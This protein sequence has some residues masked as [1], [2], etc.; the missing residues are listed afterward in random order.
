M[1]NIFYQKPCCK[2]RIEY[3]LVDQIHCMYKFDVAKTAKGNAWTKRV[4]RYC[5]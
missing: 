5:T 3:K 2:V 1:N 4:I